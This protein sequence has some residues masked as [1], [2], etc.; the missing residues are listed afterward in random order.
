MPEF[1]WGIS[2]GAILLVS[3][4]V[5]GGAEP[6]I[7]SEPRSGAERSIIIEEKGTIIIPEIPP[8]SNQP[9]RQ[10]PDPRCQQLTAEQRRNT[11]GCSRYA[12]A[13]PASVVCCLDCRP[14][15]SA[16]GGTN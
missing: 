11:R 10:S 15:S 8:P 1:L 7:P 9:S 3:A 16:S 6:R 4:S 14:T 12:S 2:I 13:F 5:S